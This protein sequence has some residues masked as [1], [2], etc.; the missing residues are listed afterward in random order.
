MS[1]RELQHSHHISLQLNIA[2]KTSPYSALVKSFLETGGWHLLW[3]KLMLW[4]WCECYDEVDICDKLMLVISMCCCNNSDI[5]LTMEFT[6]KLVY[7]AHHF[8]FLQLNLFD[9]SV[10]RV[11]L[12]FSTLYHGCGFRYQQRVLTTSPCLPISTPKFG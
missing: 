8:L 1:K 9:V 4:N 11:G 12:R 2:H 6:G 10:D 5:L 3:T 7:M